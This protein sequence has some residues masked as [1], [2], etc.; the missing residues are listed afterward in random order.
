MSLL[1]AQ[2]AIEVVDAVIS[3]TDSIEEL[4]PPEAHVIS[5]I[6]FS[7]VDFTLIM[8][9]YIRQSTK[10]LQT[11]AKFLPVS[12][13]YFMLSFA[14]LALSAGLL[15]NGETT[16]A[17]MA[18]LIVDVI[19]VIVAINALFDENLKLDWRIKKF[20]GVF[21]VINELSGI[22]ALATGLASVVFD[23]E[24]LNSRL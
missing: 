14:L 20:Y 9:V 10:P 5:N 13:A 4:L 11:L 17:L 22:I 24:R 18:A 8:G 3:S 7:V 12:T 16:E 1:I 15:A 2:L 21:W 19:A 6:A 23:V